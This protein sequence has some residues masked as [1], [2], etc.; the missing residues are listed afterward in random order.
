MQRYRFFYSTT[1][2]LALVLLPA[3][4][5]VSTFNDEARDIIL[6][7]KQ[8]VEIVLTAAEEARVDNRSPNQN[9]DG[10]ELLVVNYAGGWTERSYVRFDLSSIPHDATV[11]EA[12][13]E[14]FYHLCDGIDDIAVYTAAR[15]WTAATLTWANQPATPPSPHDM[16]NL[17]PTFLTTGNCGDTGE[18][19]AAPGGSASKPGW[20]ITKLAQN[21]VDGSAAN[22]GVVFMA[23]PELA[24]PVPPG[25]ILAIF[26]SSEDTAQFPAMP[27]RLRLTYER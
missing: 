17:G 3:C 5:S 18:Y 26:G 19:V 27:P 9:F 20:F 22:R 2:L 8:R 21:W 10:S 15:P 13:I 25:R 12:R 1:M 16:L 11:L 6:S 7:D 24:D 4:D 23:Y 14:L